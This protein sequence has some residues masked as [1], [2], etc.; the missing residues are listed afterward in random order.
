MSTGGINCRWISCHFGQHGRRQRCDV[1]PFESV[2]VF[3]RTSRWDDVGQQ[4]F[5]T[6]ISEGPLIQESLH[7]LHSLQRMFRCGTAQDK[8]I[9]AMQ[10]R[11]RGNP[12]AF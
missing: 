2:V 1:L 5:G 9:A 3:A 10:R 7:G 6:W 8:H 4:H 12:Y 11:L